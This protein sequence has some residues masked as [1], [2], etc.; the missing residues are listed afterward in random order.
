[1]VQEHILN[2]DEM[3][4][5]LKEEFVIYFKTNDLLKEI[6]EGYVLGF[7]AGQTIF[8]R[9]FKI[10]EVSDGPDKYD[11]Y[12]DIKTNITKD[13]EFYQIIFKFH[14]DLDKDRYNFHSI[15]SLLM[16]L[17]TEAYQVRNKFI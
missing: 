6:N 11:Y 8:N 7:I 5:S 10:F 17:E 14:F 16:N 2:R 9:S 15:F 3:K 1:M 4:E 12:Y 13:N